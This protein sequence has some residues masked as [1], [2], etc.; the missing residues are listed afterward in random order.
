MQGTGLG[1]FLPESLSPY[2]STACTHHVDA[3]PAGE[4]L[5][6]RPMG[7]TPIYDQVRGERINA[8]VPASGADPHRAEDHGKHRLPPDTPIPAAV[9]GPPGPGDDLAPS[10][11]HRARTHHAGLPAADGQRAATGRDREQPFPQ[12]PT[13]DKLRDTPPAV[14]RRPDPAATQRIGAQRQ[15]TAVLTPNREV[16]CDR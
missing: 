16:E 4:H 12:K 13:R 14:P 2:L 11:H 5:R 9:F 3:G 6:C 1:G 15:V 7:E 10:H 8:D